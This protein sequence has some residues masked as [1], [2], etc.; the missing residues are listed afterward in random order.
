MNLFKKLVFTDKAIDDA[1]T[2]A[3]QGQTIAIKRAVLCGWNPPDDDQVYNPYRDASGNL[4]INAV[5]NAIN[6]YFDKTEALENSV[7][8]WIDGILKPKVTKKENKNTFNFSIDFENL[9]FDHDVAADF[10]G[11]A[12]WA[13]LIAQNKELTTDCKSLLL[14]ATDPDGLEYVFA[15]AKLGDGQELKY[16]LALTEELTHRL[17]V[18]LFINISQSDNITIKYTDDGLVEYSVFEEHVKNAENIYA[19]KVDVYTKVE[20]DDKFL[21]K[22]D[23]ATIYATKEENAQ[24]A[25]KDDVYT[26]TESDGRFARSASVNGGAKVTPDSAGNLALT[27]PE[28]DLSRIKFR[29][30]YVNADSKTADKTW[31]ITANAD[32]TYTIDIFNDDWTASK[33]VNLIDEVKRLKGNVEFDNPNFNDVTE[34]GVYY[35]SHPSAENNG[36]TTNYGTLFVENGKN[37]RIA[38]TFVT[39]VDPV[40]FWFR[41]KTASGNWTNWQRC[42][43]ATELDSKSNIKSI[44]ARLFPNNLAYSSS[45]KQFYRSSNAVDSATLTESGLMTLDCNDDANVDLAAERLNDVANKADAALPKAG[46]N[47]N[48]T[49]QITWQGDNAVAATQGNLGGLEWNGATDWVKIYAENATQDNLDLV[50]D[51]GDDNSNHVSFRTS[52]NGEVAGITADG[53]YTG[54]IDWSHIN[55]R[56]NPVLKVNGTVPDASGNITIDTGGTVKSASVNGGAKVTPDSSG[57]I[58]LTVTEHAFLDEDQYEKLTETQKSNGTI[59]FVREA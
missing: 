46:G 40:G 36:P 29:K 32:G 31:N 51:L 20:S 54:K 18:D 25:N 11:Y 12:S 10:F 45:T 35:V 26:K 57:N 8:P 22:T 27:V 24:K 55:G 53:T 21:T 37:K 43:N 42:A 15:F 38:Q 33:L 28:A 39:D 6:K 1:T 13:E 48:L 34:T 5:K 17:H 50:I 14:L 19:K 41:S 2:A 9:N 49:S 4:D 47:M 59:Y 16:P 23:A 30:Q 7:N 52:R 56:P 58:A 44:Q 3:E